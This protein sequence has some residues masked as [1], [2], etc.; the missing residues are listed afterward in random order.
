MQKL[1]LKYVGELAYALH[2]IV[3]LVITACSNS[4]NSL[5]RPKDL[6]LENTFGQWVISLF[7]AIFGLLCVMIFGWYRLYMINNY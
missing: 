4:K 5:I 1:R 6:V 7:S 2:L 3:F